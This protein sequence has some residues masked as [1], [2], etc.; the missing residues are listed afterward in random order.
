[1]CPAC[2]IPVNQVNSTTDV[3]AQSN[4]RIGGAI[5]AGIGSAINVHGWTNGRHSFDR[6]TTFAE[7]NANLTAEAALRANASTAIRFWQNFREVDFD[8]TSNSTLVLPY[9]RCVYPP[10]IRTLPGGYIGGNVTIAA[11]LPG[12][13]A[14]GAIQAIGGSAGTMIPVPPIHCVGSGFSGPAE[15]ITLQPGQSETLQFNG[16]LSLGY[17]L[18]GLEPI[19][20]QIYNLRIVGAQN[21]HTSIN[22]TASRTHRFQ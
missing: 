5:N 18:V 20:G 21:A 22:V 6:T 4:A 8:I 15:G 1:M 2:V 10:N 11:K 14:N 16:E 7:S 12:G 9:D 3:T 19:I 13:Y 17:G